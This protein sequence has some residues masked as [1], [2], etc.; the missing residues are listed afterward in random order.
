MSW[1]KVDDGTHSHKK[2]R[3]AGVEAMGLWVVCGSWSAAH[4]ED[5]FVPTYVAETFT[6][7]A[8][9]YAKRLVS[10]GLWVPTT[11]DGD[12]GWRFHDWDAYQPMRD[13]VEAKRDAWRER[14]RKARSQGKVSRSDNGVSHAPVTRES[15]VSH[16]ESHAPVTESRPVPS[17]PTEEVPSSSAIASDRDN[18]SAAKPDD[19]PRPEVVELCDYLAELVRANGHDVRTVGKL[20][21]RSCRLLI[22]KDGR[23]PDQVR[24]AIEWATADPFWSTNIRSMQSLREKYTTLQAQAN[25]RRPGNGNVSRNGIDW[26]ATLTEALEADR[27]N[28]S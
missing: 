24:A 11:K 17:R 27:R 21:H 20:W 9:Q 2:T 1:F 3:R 10:A 14:Q 6:T 26:Q 4:L 28:A 18:D 16:G 15:R 5:G 7:R 8:H 19:N 25:G 12:E 22:D 13:V 23:T